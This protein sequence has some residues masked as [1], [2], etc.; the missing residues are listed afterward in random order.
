MNSGSGDRPLEPVKLTFAVADACTFSC[1]SDS[2]EGAVLN[3]TVQ[4]I[5]PSPCG[6]Y[7]NY[8]SS[9]PLSSVYRAA[10]PVLYNVTVTASHT[11]VLAGQLLELIATARL[12][13]SLTMPLGKFL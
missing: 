1:R 11:T 10:G 6:G 2:A 5:V 3:T 13:A 9:L 7:S 8:T 12:L 4:S